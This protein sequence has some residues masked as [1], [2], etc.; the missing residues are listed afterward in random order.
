MC[1]GLKEAH[2]QGIV[3]RDLKPENVMID[4]HG[5]VKIMDFGIARSWKRDALTG[6]W[7]ARLRIWLPSKCGQDGRS[8]RGYLRHG[9]D[10]L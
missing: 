9:F 6:G 2:A 7:W 4:T 3:H 1:S 8:S 5:N 10:A